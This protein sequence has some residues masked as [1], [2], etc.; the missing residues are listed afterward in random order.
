MLN[1]DAAVQIRG[2]T[3]F[4]DFNDPQLYWYMPNNP[5]LARE[6]RD[7]LFQLLLYRDN[8]TPPATG[9]TD[10]GGGFLTMT[11]DLGVS[12]STLE[13]IKGELSNTAGGEV[14]LAPV[15]FESGSVRV[16]SLGV[17]GGAAGG[18][19][20]GGGDDDAA[21]PQSHFVEKM[22][23][24]T[25]PSMYGDNRAAFSFELSQKGAIL[26]EASLE[27]DGAS[28]IAVLY[29]LEYM[30]LKPAREVKIVIEYEQSYRHLRSRMQVNTLWFKS[31]ID[32]EMERMRKNGS[33]TIEDVNYMELDADKAAE[34]AKELQT[35]AKE[36][37]QWTFFKPSL[38][39]GNVLAAE[40]GNLTVYDPT[41]AAVANTAGFTT[42]L[43]LLP[44]GRNRTGDGPVVNSGVT[45]R[46][47]GVRNRTAN[48]NTNTNANTNANTT[49]NPPN[50]ATTPSGQARQPTAVERWNA[51]GRPQA[52]FLMRE[53][54]QSESQRIEFNLRQ[55][56]AHKRPASPQGSIRLLAGD[57]DLRGRIKRVDLDDPFWKTIGGTITSNADFDT[58]GVSSM[59][60][61]IRYGLRP[62]GTGPKDSKEFVLE[63]GGDEGKYEFFL[64]HQKSLEYEYKV[65][66]NYKAEYAIGSRKTKA[67]SEWIRTTTQNLDI[68]PRELRAVLPVRVTAGQVDWDAVKNLQTTITYRD[69]TNGIDAARTVTISQADSSATIPIR[70]EDQSVQKYVV[71]STYFYDDTRETVEEV[72]TRGLEVV[73]NQPPSKAVPVSISAQD[74]LL[75]LAKV[76]VELSYTPEGGV[77]QRKLMT[78]TGGETK[79]WTFFRPAI[80]DDARYRYRATLFGK[81]GTTDQGEW[82]ET[83]ER[84]VIVGDRFPGM[85]DVEVQIIGD[86]A[87]SNIQIARLKLEYPGA[88]EGIDNRDERALRGVPEPFKWT[89]PSKTREAGEYQWEVMW[90]FNDRTM[91]TEKG[92][93]SDELLFLF[94]P[95]AE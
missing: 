40:R 93:S 88:P 27:D 30:G 29:D 64:D 68:D 25:K 45:N 60:I 71:T 67:E 59:V 74:P 56:S 38:R 85:L 18:T 79:T 16:T 77:E 48:T 12:S 76:S 95:T 86:L 53:L 70:P 52:G 11:V 39:P 43:N 55:V 3:L 80:T 62:D 35:L 92:T 47:G 2:L 32:S 15:P 26:M 9:D 21:A 5:R 46:T 82:I 8:A 78:L 13:A 63:K 24:F 10:R 91:K 90:V 22:L 87:E 31:D 65:T 33:I 23:G 94:V 36:L 17:S 7:P 14:R 42:P 41:T 89:V 73:L 34:R 61:S 57:S 49:N 66:A 51:A 58:A 28:A 54:N 4:R 19:T 81:N 44:G 50:A 84:Q 37:A 83:T 6:G 1:L 75:R 69:P 20:A 72:R